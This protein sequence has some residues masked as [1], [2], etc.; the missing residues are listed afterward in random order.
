M[1]QPQLDDR[2]TPDTGAPSYLPT[3]QKGGLLPV[4]ACT[5]ANAPDNWSAA[6]P[7]TLPRATATLTVS[8]LRTRIGAA[9]IDSLINNGMGASPR[10]CSQFGGAQS[11]KE[12]VA[13]P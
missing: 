11:K 4:G 9:L 13:E 10:N 12:E 1:M 5:S 6:A 3:K 2:T 8:T 7:S